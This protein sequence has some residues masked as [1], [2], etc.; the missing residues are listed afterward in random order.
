MGETRRQSKRRIPWLR[1]NRYDPWRPGKT[2][3]LDRRLAT[4]H[5][6]GPCRPTDRSRRRRPLP[7]LRCRQLLYRKQPDHRRRLHLL[8]TKPIWIAARRRKKRKRKT[9]KISRKGAKVRDR[10]TA[11]ERRLTRIGNQEPERSL[12]KPRSGE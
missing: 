1:G 8:V 11:D 12:V 6:H 7:S 2:P 5:T 3:R 9:K 4:I 10:Q